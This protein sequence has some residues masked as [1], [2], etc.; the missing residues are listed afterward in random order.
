MLRK[1]IIRLSIAT[2]TG[3]DYYMSMPILDLPDI[4]D[5]VEEVNKEINGQ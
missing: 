5:D 3:I 1:S 4:I 2:F